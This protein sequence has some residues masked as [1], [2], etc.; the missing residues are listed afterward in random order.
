VGQPKNDSAWEVPV[1]VRR[2]EPGPITIPA[3]L[4][5]RSSFLAQV[6]RAS[7]VEEWRTKVI[8]ER[9]ELEEEAFVEFKRGLPGKRK[10]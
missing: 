4:A 3:D 6:H 7:G 9:I 1:Q 10:A 5:A 8:R 2:G